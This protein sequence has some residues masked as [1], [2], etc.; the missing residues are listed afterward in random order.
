[1]KKIKNERVELRCESCGRDFLRKKSDVEWRIRYGQKHWF[2]LQ[3]CR[4][5]FCGKN[6]GFGAHPK[7]E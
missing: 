7:K 5:K 3:T 6:Y 2:C 4:S 1:M